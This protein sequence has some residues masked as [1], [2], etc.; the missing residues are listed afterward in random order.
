[1]ELKWKGQVTRSDPP[2]L[3][4]TASS[5]KPLPHFFFSAICLQVIS[6]HLAAFS[7]T[8]GVVVCFPPVVLSSWRVG[9]ELKC[10]WD[11]MLKGVRVAE[12]LGVWVEQHSKGWNVLGSVVHVCNASSLGG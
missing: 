11:I 8:P 5:S 12:K 3:P 2:L 1:M 9:A 10:C 4:L 6:A 7:Q